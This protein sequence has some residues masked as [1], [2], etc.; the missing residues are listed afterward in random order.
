M[1]AQAAEKV[2]VEM[3]R[4]SGAKALFKDKLIAALQR[5]LEMSPWEEQVGRNYPERAPEERNILAPGRE[6]GGKVELV[7][8]ARRAQRQP[9][10]T[11]LGILTK[12]RFFG[13]PHFSHS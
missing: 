9:S 12:G 7:S 2:W 10:C 1:A 5:V 8:R 13:F 3:I 6:S 11:R 4:R